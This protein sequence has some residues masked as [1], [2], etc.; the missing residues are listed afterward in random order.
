MIFVHILNNIIHN[1][2]EVLCPLLLVV[3]GTV[4]SRFRQNGA[5]EP[6]FSGKLGHGGVQLPSVILLYI[7]GYFRQNGA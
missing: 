7:L 4:A 6:P 5:S 3:D 2:F 1:A